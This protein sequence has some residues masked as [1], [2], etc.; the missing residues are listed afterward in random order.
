MVLFPRAKINLGLSIVSKREDGFHNIETLFYPVNLCDVLEFVVSGGSEDK[1]TVTGIDIGGSMNDNLVIRALKKL[2]ESYPVPFLDIHLHK[3]IPAGA[4]LGGG[5]S[6]AGCM[7]RS[8]SKYFRTGTDTA[9]LLEI[10]ASLGSDCPF[11]IEGRPAFAGGRGEIL[12]PAPDLLHGYYLVILNP[13][14]HSDTREAY[15]NCKPSTPAFSVQDLPRIHVE[16][17]KLHLKNDFEEF[18]FR[19]H[20]ITGQLKNRLYESGAIYSS[21]SGSGSSVFGIFSGQPA[22][23]GDLKEYLIWEGPS[24]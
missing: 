8:V 20:P 7:L 21:M 14:I 3:V 23:P 10:A 24:D 16:D 13:G 6:D 15:R 12:S 22:L 4:G 11:F 1:F 17:W 5:S 18:V 2:R 19:Q 9:E